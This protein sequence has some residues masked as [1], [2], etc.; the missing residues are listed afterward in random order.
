MLKKRTDSFGRLLGRNE[1]QKNDGRYVFRYRNLTGETKYTYSWRLMDTDELPKGKRKCKSLREK[2]E[3][4]N[5]EKMWEAKGLKVTDRVVVSELVDN[6]LSFRINVKESTKAGYKTVRKLLNADEFGFRKIDRIS[7]KDAK[8]W[9]M[10]LQ[11]EGRGYSSIHAVRGVLRPAFQMAVE[12]GL[13]DRNP[14]DFIFEGVVINDMKRIGALTALEE[15]WF[16]AFVHD[17]DHF[18][19]HYD[20]FILLFETG[21]RISEMCGLGLND[22]DFEQGFIEISKTLNRYG[23]RYVVSTT[24][25]PSG[26]R[27]IPMSKN[28]R[29]SLGRIIRIRKKKVQKIQVEGIDDLVF[30]DGR[31][32]PILPNMVEK[33]FQRCREKMKQATGR[34]IYVTPHVCRHTFCSK[35]VREGMHPKMLQYIMGH[36]KIETTLDCY[37]HIGYDQVAYEFAKIEK[38]QMPG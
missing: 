31:G 4:I 25:T 29:N 7:V 20:M 37:T 19:R 21:I 35:M 1:Y 10:K 32:V 5:S 13:L 26:F 11:A 38:Q 3:E 30:I 6:Y 18:K 2:E 28:V 36:S 22:V 16:L 34:Y 14:F 33:Y 12:D 8:E 24:K 27:R 9:L 17:D 23:K 15:K